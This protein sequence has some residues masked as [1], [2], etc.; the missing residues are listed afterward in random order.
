MSVRSR[1]IADTLLDE[2]RRLLLRQGDR[3]QRKLHSR[4]GRLLSTRRASIIYRG[5]DNEFPMLVMS[6]SLYMRFLDMKQLHYG[7]KEVR[8]NRKIYNRFYGSFVGR[9][10]WRLRYDFTE[11][12]RRAISSA[13]SDNQ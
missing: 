9:L 5:L 1:F 10:T 13:L 4:T 6:W 12:T 3:I 8:R 11:E 2:G 7:G